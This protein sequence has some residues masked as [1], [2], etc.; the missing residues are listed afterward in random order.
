MEIK[1]ND[2]ESNN[3][4]DLSSIIPVDEG[5]KSKQ[6]TKEEL[7][8]LRKQMMKT[9]SKNLFSNKTNNA[10]QDA[11]STN[12]SIFLQNLDISFKQKN[13]QDSFS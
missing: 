13:L 4:M 7:Y 2:T 3:I 12:Q 1:N 11:I 10:K 6:K 5:K 9:N 8:K